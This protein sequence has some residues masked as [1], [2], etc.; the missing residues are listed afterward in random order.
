MWV[1]LDANWISVQRWCRVT[2]KWLALFLLYIVQR[3]WEEVKK[4]IGFKCDLTR[5]AS[6][7]PVP[8]IIGVI[9]VPWCSI[10]GLFFLHHSKFSLR[11]GYQRKEITDLNSSRAPVAAAM[12]ELAIV[13]QMK[14]NSLSVVQLFSLSSY[15]NEW[16]NAQPPVFQHTDLGLI[17]VIGYKWHTHNLKI[18]CPPVS[19]SLWSSF[20]KMVI[21]FLEDELMIIRRWISPAAA[22]VRAFVLFCA[23][24]QTDRLTM[25]SLADISWHRSVPSVSCF[26]WRTSEELGVHVLKRIWFHPN[27]STKKKVYL[28]TRISIWMDSE[29]SADS[30][31]WSSRSSSS[32]SSSVAQGK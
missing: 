27:C 3:W 14:W 19:L 10:E 9:W 32:S 12:I 29:I 2:P 11:E 13:C 6:S 21:Q 18:D 23:W 24:L 20:S 16:M 4:K 5:V 8:V 31:A 22:N 28:P 7:V 15:S 1:A 17:C 26:S 25:F 30:S